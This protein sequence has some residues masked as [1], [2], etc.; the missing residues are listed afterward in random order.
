MNRVRNVIA[1]IIS[2]CNYVGMAACF[3]CVIIVA[4]DVILRKV[5]GQEYSIKGSNELSTFLLLTMCM[6]A[7]PVLQIRKGHV[8]VNMFVDRMPRRMPGE[9][10][11]GSFAAYSVCCSCFS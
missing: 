9:V 4:A 8:W 3:A 10:R 11:G 6:L 2:I 5:S 7:I 1:R